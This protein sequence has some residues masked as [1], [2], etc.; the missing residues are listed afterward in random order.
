FG[1]EVVP[2]SDLGELPDAKELKAGKREVEMAQQLIDSLATDFDPDRYRDEYRQSVLDLIERKA[3]GHD[4]TVQAAPE[5][6]AE[7]PDLMAAL[8]ASIASAKRQGGSSKGAEGQKPKAKSAS[9]G[10]KSASN[11]KKSTSGS[12]QPASKSKKSASDSKQPAKRTSAK[13]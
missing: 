10:K 4:V 2:P 9:N 5:A 8:E 6:P 7:V 12:T 11:G 13:K 3:E 1:D